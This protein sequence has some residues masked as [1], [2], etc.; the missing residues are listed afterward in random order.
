VGTTFT[1]V[2]PIRRVLP[3]LIV[4]G[5]A[6]AGP[7]GGS[8][9]LPAKERKPAPDFALND[10]DG[11]RVTLAAHRGRVVLL[12]FWATWC[13]GCKV[14]IPWY[15]E[16]QKKF[17]QQGLT[18]IGVAM[19]DEGWKIVKPYLEKNPINYPIVLG[20][21]DL[22]TP[23]RIAALPVTVLI[24][25]KGKIADTHVG[26]VDKDTWERQIRQLLSERA[27]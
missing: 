4:A 22:V 9:L 8:G 20:N 12:D 21:P 26:V 5:V 18:S 11:T 1:R 14:E 2:N 24:D 27:R 25:R 6:M 15:I 10:L 3:L 13:A 7:V 16:F 17:A 19:D 23:Y